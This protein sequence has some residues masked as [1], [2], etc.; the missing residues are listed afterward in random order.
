MHPDKSAATNQTGIRL[1]LY[2]LLFLFAGAVFLPLFPQV[3]PRP[4]LAAAQIVPAVL[5][6]LVHGARIYTRRGILV[7]AVISMAVGFAMEAMGVRTGFPFGHYYFTDAMGPKLFLV[8]I[9][10]G[11]AYLGMGYVSWTV[12][13]VILDHGRSA[14]AG[15]GVVLLPLAA[16]FVM[17][18]WDISLDPALSTVGRYW[19][20]TQGGAYFGV[21]VSNFLGWYLTN[22]LIYQLF[23]LHL[24]RRSTATE[25]AP[26]LDARLAV[27][28]YA[29]CAAGCVLRTASKPSSAV[30]ADATGTLWQVGSINNV[31]ALAAIFIMGAFAVFAFGRLGTG[32]SDLQIAAHD[33]GTDGSKVDAFEPEQLEQVS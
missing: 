15:L 8:P 29:I 24:R 27:F 10:M 22:Y 30:V 11:P 3:F 13:R 23:A 4:V 14:F 2:A 21:P 5:F 1:L 16:S 9:L 33:I 6:A 25:L 26:L 28:F 12:A 18:A 31:C 19:I 17:V 32:A 20:W 7:F